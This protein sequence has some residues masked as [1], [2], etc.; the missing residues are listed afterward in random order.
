MSKHSFCN[1]NREHD[2]VTIWI[3]ENFGPHLIGASL[4]NAVMQMAFCRIFNEP[5]TLRLACPLG[6]LPAAKYSITARKEFGKKVFRGA[7]IMPAHE[8]KGSGAIDYWFRAL[9]DLSRI[10][11]N[12]V[13]TLREV[14][15]RM[16]TV[17]G[18][19]EFVANQVCAD[20]R[21]CPGL[22]FSDWGEFVL[23][24][25]GTRRGLN[26]LSSRPVSESLNQLKARDEIAE[27]RPI[28]S[29]LNP[30]EAAYFKDPNNVANSLCEF[31]KHE[32]Y[33]DEGDS[34]RLK[35]YGRNKNTQSNLI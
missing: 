23:C 31:D 27:L 14:A 29:E 9:E 12:G 13:Q 17:K 24:G 15:E 33:A 1:I 34:A 11:F 4:G 6:R 25:P 16:M 21:Y 5:E 20:L 28:I 18:F 30:R 35:K 8:A 2:A 22:N 32:R 7:Y 3:R 26:R 10:D 19:A